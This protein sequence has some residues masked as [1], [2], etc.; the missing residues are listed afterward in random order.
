MNNKIYK[1][2]N[3][4]IVLFID[5][6]TTNFRAYKYDLSNNKILAKIENN[7]GILNIKKKSEFLHILKNTLIKLKLSK[8]Q[9]IL[10]AGMVGSKKGLYEVPYVKIPASFKYFAKK[11][12]IKSIHGIYLNII[13]GLLFKKNNSCPLCRQEI[14]CII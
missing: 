12:K 9:F 6:G 4:N 14:L 13:P 7:K 3:K 11:L 8:K 1:N 10:M 2:Y 5:W